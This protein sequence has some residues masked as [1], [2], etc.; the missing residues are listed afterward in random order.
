MTQE[1]RKETASFM[2]SFFKTD[3]KVM[4]AKVTSVSNYVCT[5]QY[6]GAVLEARLKATEDDSKEAFVLIPRVNSNVLICPIEGSNYYVVIATDEVDKIEYKANNTVLKI[7]KDG[8]EI[9]SGGQVKINNASQSL[10]SLIDELCDALAD[11]RVLETDQGIPKPSNP[12]PAT[13]AKIKAIQNKF[14]SLLKA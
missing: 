6:D 13:V 12:F 11:F 4:V 10:G 9:T 14:K 7:N 1:L 3:Q 2:S 8:I 5:V